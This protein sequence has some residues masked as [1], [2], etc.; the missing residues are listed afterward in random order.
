MFAESSPDGRKDP[1]DWGVNWTDYPVMNLHPHSWPLYSTAKLLGVDFHE[2]G[3][4]FKPALPLAEYEF[5]SPLLGF[6]K[7]AIGY[8]GW[9]APAAAGRWTI[10][11]QLSD[12]ERSSLRQIKVNGS[13]EPLPHGTQTIRLIGES[14]R[15]TPLR[16]EIS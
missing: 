7:S 2:T 10:E 4:R 15:D 3:V 9:Y 14:S 11:I 16:W 6:S 13:V 5:S 1:S 12:L 8:L